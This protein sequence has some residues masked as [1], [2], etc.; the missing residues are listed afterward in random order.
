MWIIKKVQ[1]TNIFLAVVSSA[2]VIQSVFPNH[3]FSQ[4]GESFV[5]AYH[6]FVL[7]IWINDALAFFSK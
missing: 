7:E 6:N 3:I 5:Y 2:L 1:N 4:T